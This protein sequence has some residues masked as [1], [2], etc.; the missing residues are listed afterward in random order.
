MCP[1]FLVHALLFS[2]LELYHINKY[3]F[4]VIFSVVVMQAT[5]KKPQNT[6]LQN[7]YIAFDDIFSDYTICYI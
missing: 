2:M 4:P 5:I 7:L 1:E 6:Q 3:R